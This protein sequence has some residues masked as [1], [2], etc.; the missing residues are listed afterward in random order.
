LEAQAELLALLPPAR[1]GAN[2]I[3]QLISLVSSDTAYFGDSE[4]LRPPSAAPSAQAPTSKGSDSGE[5]EIPEAISPGKRGW[6][7][8]AK[9]PA[10]V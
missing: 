4:P 5:D 3:Q 6:Y 8:A 1:P 2:H 10:A 9:W 7:T